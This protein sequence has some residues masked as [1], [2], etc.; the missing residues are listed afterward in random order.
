MALGSDALDVG[1]VN[2]SRGVEDWRVRTPS[3]HQ[4]LGAPAGEARDTP[5]LPAHRMRRHRRRE[6]QLTI[7]QFAQALPLGS[8]RCS[9]RVDVPTTKPV[10]LF[11]DSPY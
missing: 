9:T 8:F 10:G 3:M 1:L 11:G 4:L 6:T 2:E 5:A 7:G